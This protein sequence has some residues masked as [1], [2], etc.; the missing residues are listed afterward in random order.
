[1][2]AT[3]LPQP[4]AQPTTMK[5]LR[6]RLTFLTPS[7]LGDAEQN[8]RWRTPPFKAQ[9]RQWWRVAYAAEKKFT[10]DVQA[11]RREEG[12]LFGNAWLDNDFCKSLVRLRMERWHKGTLTNWSADQTVR[13]PERPQPVGAQLYLGYGPLIF[14]QG[15]KLKTNA[16]IQAG[17]TAALAVAFPD[18]HAKRL[19]CALSLMHRFGA[20]GGRSRNGWGSYVL[21]PAES[22]SALSGPVP[23]RNWKECLQVDWPH[24]I[25]QDDKGPLIWQTAP[26]ADWKALMK[27]LAIIKIGMRTQ[28]RFPNA[29]PPHQNIERRHWLSYPITTH[30]T[31]AWD[32]GARLPNQLRFKARNTADGQLVGVIFHMPHLPPAAFDPQRQAIE[33]VWSEV[34]GFLDRQ[35]PAQLSRAQA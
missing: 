5:I 31:R 17:E 29:R 24:A 4:A 19:E 30:A 2:S 12:L 14:R 16:A 6:Y 22:T 21:E 27:T 11:M 18:E 25:G 20:V 1:M 26:H 8:G 9:L 15:T 28:F 35:T 10:V 3:I 33:Q 7:F 13:H 23:L 32:R 34:H